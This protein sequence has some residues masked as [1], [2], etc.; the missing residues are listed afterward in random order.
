MWLPHAR[1]KLLEVI[2]F[3]TNHHDGS[4]D[5]VRIKYKRAK[6]RKIPA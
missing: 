1:C 2:Q 3:Y 4:L 5:I 6:N